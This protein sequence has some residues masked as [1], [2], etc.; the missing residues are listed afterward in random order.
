MKKYILL[1]AILLVSCFLF[2][3]N[4][5]VTTGYSAGLGLS[6]IPDLYPV[7]EPGVEKVDMYSLYAGT[8]WNVRSNISAKVGLNTVFPLRKM[9]LIASEDS[10]NPTLTPVIMDVL[11]GAVYTK[12]ISKMFVSVEGHV[13]Y[14]ILHFTRI[15]EPGFVFSG[16]VGFGY[17]FKNLAISAYIGY[18]LRN[19]LVYT[20]YGA[21]GFS[22]QSLPI[23]V[24]ASYQF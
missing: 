16:R 14:S 15:L 19:Y 9:F 2:A 6:S 22:I 3:F 4:L 23:G 24:G 10:E 18:E 20:V 11:V 12:N 13:G 8:R 5:E 17:Q 21:Q 1:I 7:T